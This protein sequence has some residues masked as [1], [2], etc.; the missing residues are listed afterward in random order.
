MCV[1]CGLSLWLVKHTHSLESTEP[2]GDGRRGR[3][4]E[5]A[6]AGRGGGAGRQ[7]AGSR[8]AAAELRRTT[9]FVGRKSVSTAP[10]APS[11]SA[12][13]PRRR[14]RRQS[15]WCPQPPHIRQAQ[16][17]PPVRRADLP[18]RWRAAQCSLSPSNG[19]WQF[20]REN[21]TRTHSQ[22]GGRAHCA[23][24]TFGRRRSRE[25]V[26]VVPCVDCVCNART[27][28]GGRAG[29]NVGF[30]MKQARLWRVP[31]GS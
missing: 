25:M 31:S 27:E 19:S 17:R 30:Q 8:Q 14:R 22:S 10:A 20:S 7:T 16:C 24:E 2:G 18:A 12:G 6:R 3:N 23:C 4:L 26:V 28:G 1:C 15:G 21:S 9:A 13:R 29:A 5:G 11:W